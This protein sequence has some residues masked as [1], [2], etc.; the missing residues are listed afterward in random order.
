MPKKDKIINKIFSKAEVPIRHEFR[1]EI[2]HKIKSAGE[3]NLSTKE[4]PMKMFLKIFAGAA[5]VCV[6]IL[7][8]IIATKFMPSLNKV[9]Q[10]AQKIKIGEAL[11]R[12]L[13]NSFSLK[14]DNLFKYKK[15]SFS[16]NSN[17][18][19]MTFRDNMEIWE[20]KNNVREDR[21]RIEK[22]NSSDAR[23]SKDELDKL[24]KGWVSIHSEIDLEKEN[25]H[26]IF[27]QEYGKEDTKFLECNKID[28]NNSGYL[29]SREGLGN[30]YL[31]YDINDKS[32]K[33]YLIEENGNIYIEW[34]SNDPYDMIF[35]DLGLNGTIEGSI[36]KE[37]SEFT[38]KKIGDQYYHRFKID[39]E[40][41]VNKLHASKNYFQF[42]IVT[43]NYNDNIEPSNEVKF[44]ASAIYQYNFDKK[45]L[46]ALTDE[47]I[48]SLKDE[49]KSRAFVEKYYQ[50]YFALPLELMNKKE[51]LNNPIEQ[52]EEI[53]N[54]KKVIRV[55]YIL[56]D[57]IRNKFISPEG[58]ISIEFVFSEEENKVYEYAIFNE[59]NNLALIHKIEIKDEKIITDE[60][61]EE[62]FTEEYWKND[63][64][65]EI[66][67]EDLKLD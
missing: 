12:S 19:D 1:Q 36:Q 63:L 30:S 56:T 45:E 44:K 64:P 3:K 51:L 33:P 38:N 57:D 24:K 62:F 54:N 8:L 49:V 43:E 60:N 42:Q 55:K 61:P 28:E 31:F 7:A 10:I 59:D 14:R 67:T 29:Q 6:I 15:I 35:L 25:K 21:I 48:K 13:E 23:L 46:L 22:G 40:K 50:E 58:K 37:D 27:D 17:V 26:C 20:Y 9:N 11:A 41:I 2:Y 34:V 47:E 52:K 32:T 16:S 4:N 5:G 53:R 66:N 65:K 39:K 18:E